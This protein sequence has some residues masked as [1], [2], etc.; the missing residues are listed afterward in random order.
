MFK[1][2]HLLQLYFYVSAYRDQI[3]QHD[4]NPPI[5]ILVCTEKGA[6]MV[7]YAL[8]GMEEKL[9]VSNYLIKLPSK[10]TLAHFI[11]TEIIRI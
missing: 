4:D 8:A 7:E 6:N 11:E 2:E 1:H 9:F 3:M 5:G 10:E